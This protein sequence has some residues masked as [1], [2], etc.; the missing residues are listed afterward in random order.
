MSKRPL[1]VTLIG[2]FVIV[3]AAL[4][5]FSLSAARSNPD[6]LAQMLPPGATPEMLSQAI[7]IAMFASVVIGLIGIGLLRG[8]NWA[9][10][11]MVAIAI[12]A[13]LMGV[14]QGNPV[15]LLSAAL[16]GGLAFLL[17]RRQAS[18]FFDLK[19]RRHL[20]PGPGNDGNPPSSGSNTGTFIA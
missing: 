15:M 2:I 1:S 20:P 6:L 13:L 16:Q 11:A 4:N 3:Q 5:L 8:L 18:A 12:L 14:M 10:I 19:R 9:R 7:P 17:Y